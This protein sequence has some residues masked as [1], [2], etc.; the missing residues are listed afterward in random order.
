[1]EFQGD[2]AVAQKKKKSETQSK[3]SGPS[4]AAM[5]WILFAFMIGLALGS[6]IGYNVGRSASAGDRGAGEDRYGRSPGN[7]HYT[8]NHP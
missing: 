3:P 4:R 2:K 1:M 6:V 5:Q 7:A 8:H